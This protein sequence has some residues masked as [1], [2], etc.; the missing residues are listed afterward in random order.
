MKHDDKGQQALLHGFGPCIITAH[1][2]F[3]PPPAR[4]P[5]DSAPYSGRRSSRSWP[6]LPLLATPRTVRHMIGRRSIYLG[7][8]ALLL[9]LLLLP[10]PLGRPLTPRGTLQQ[11][12]QTPP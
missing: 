4:I 11:H 12:R 8:T 3:W 6:G 7:G 9:L 1:H 2:D 10:L 5:H